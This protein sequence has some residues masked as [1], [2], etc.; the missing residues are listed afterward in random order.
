MVNSR[1]DIARRHKLSRARVTQIMCLLSLPQSIRE[2][3]IALPHRQQCLCSER[4]LREIVH[5]G[6]EQAQVAAFESLVEAD[7]P[8]S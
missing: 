5:T 3:I 7:N 2:Y 1:A 8:K 4:R 6:P